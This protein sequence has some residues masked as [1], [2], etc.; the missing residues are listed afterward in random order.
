M[1]YLV[2]SDIHGNLEAFESFL[3]FI[4]RKK[5]DKY[6]FLGDIVGYGA[7]PNE[8]IQQLKKLKPLYAVRGNHDKAV[9]GEEP[10]EAFNPVAANAI[11]WTRKKIL[12]ENLKYLSK[13]KKG[14]IVVDKNITICHG[15]PFDEDYYIFGDFD[16]A[17]AFYYIKTPVCFFGHTHFPFVYRLKKNLIDGFLVQGKRKIIR[18]EKDVRYLINPGSIGQPRDRNPFLSFAIFDSKLMKINFY[19]IEYDIEKAKKR[20]MEANLPPTLAERLSL[21]I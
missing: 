5:I 15:A 2:F 19:R 4:K 1:K 11:Q 13:L 20:I 14:P 18:L 7:S 6:L 3:K 10:L 9:C 21:G 17:E 8:T 16:A 12:K